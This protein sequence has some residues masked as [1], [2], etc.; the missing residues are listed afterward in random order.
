MV[1]QKYQIFLDNANIFLS[2]ISFFLAW[3]FIYKTIPILRKNFIQI[4]NIRSSHS[5]PI[6]TGGGVV[7]VLIGTF[8]SFLLGNYKL[9]IILP[10]GLI[11]FLD[12]FFEVSKKIRLSAQIITSL[13][14][15]KDSPIIKIIVNQFPD[16]LF[17]ITIPLLIIFS[18]ALIN[19]LNF[20]DG[21]DGLVVNCMIVY[22]FVFVFL[23]SPNMLPLVAS[24]LAFSLWNFPPAK[25]FM[26][27]IG[28]TFLGATLVMCIFHQNNFKEFFAFILLA[29]PLIFDSSICL[30]RRLYSSHKVF[31][32]HKLHLYQR[33][34]QSGW[35][36]LK[37]SLLYT[38]TTIIL[39]LS[40]LSFGLYALLFLS[41][42]LI[43]FGIFI[44]KNY[45]TSFSKLD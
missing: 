28:S 5:K 26:G 14:I 3:I 15:I 45:A 44:E 41:L 2:I 16:Y 13:F 40:Y 18:V 31:E 23:H 19:F 17:F 30:I 39:S 35:S 6:P 22:L 32:A 36:H 38:M 24:M 7:F 9:L 42:S 12:D 8:F 11:G 33:L 43:P 21:L 4:P 27:D 25:V 10:L 20:M 34:H 37:V 1:S 29:S